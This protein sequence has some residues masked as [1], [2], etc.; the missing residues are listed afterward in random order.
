MPPPPYT[1]FVS[2]PQRE[3]AAERRAIRDFVEADPLL[4]QPMFLARYIERAGTGT[5]DMPALSRDAGLKE[6][7]FRFEHGQFIQVLWRPE[8]VIPQV[9]PQV[10]P[11]AAPEVAHQA[12][13]EV[14]ALVKVLGGSMSRWQIQQALRL[15]DRVNLRRLYL[16]PAL[17]DNLIVRTLP[18][19]IS[20][21]LQRYQLTPAGHALRQRLL[22]LNPDAK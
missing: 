18:Q 10:T 13:P 20:S 17:A 9:T 6:P 5:L 16:A 19:S 21:P 1:V 11:E 22:T 15:K 7:Q 4:A 2:S 8:A 14:A 3:L 12:T